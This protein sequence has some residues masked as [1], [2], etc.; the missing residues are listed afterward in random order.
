M[1]EPKKMSIEEM[2]I[3]KNRLIDERKALQKDLEYI[4]NDFDAALIEKK[5]EVLAKKI[6]NL[7]DKIEEAKS[8]NT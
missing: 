5:R 4:E 6:K 1:Q 3:Q 7:H 8:S 2:E